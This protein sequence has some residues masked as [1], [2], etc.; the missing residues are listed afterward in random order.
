MQNAR[1]AQ[2]RICLLE[3]NMASHFS[4]LQRATE[5]MVV[6]DRAGCLLVSSGLPCDSFNVLFCRDQTSDAALRESVSYFQ[7][8][9][10]PFG[11]WVG[12]QAL[13]APLLEQLG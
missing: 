4:Y 11:V 8:R 10:L 6:Q 13:V 12:P 5:G 9:Q 2:A 7:S 1:R 3:Q